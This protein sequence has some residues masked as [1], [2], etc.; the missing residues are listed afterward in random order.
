MK[1]LSF[2]YFMLL[3]VFSKQNNLPNKIKILGSFELIR[4]GARTP[5]I[6]KEQS[7]LYFGT[8]RSQLTINGFRQHILLGRWLRRRYVLED[9][10]PL[11]KTDFNLQN[12]DEIKIKSSNFQRCVFSA[13]AH[14]LGLFPKAIIKLNYEGHQEIK[15]NDIPPIKNYIEDIRDGR[16]VTIN[17][18]NNQKENLFKIS[19][20]KYKN[21]T[22]TLKQEIKK[23]HR[24]PINLLTDNEIK[25]AIDDIMTN[26]KEVIIK[27]KKHT[28]DNE[29]AANNLKIHKNNLRKNNLN[30]SEIPKYS[31]H[32]LNEFIS[33]LRPYL[34]HHKMKNNLKNSTLLTIKK[35]CLNKV[36]EV[37][38]KDSPQKL[39]FSSRIFK[40][41]K[42]FFN[43]IIEK[44]TKLKLMILS[45]FDRNI[46]DVISNLLDLNYLKKIIFDSLNDKTLYNFLVPKFASNMIFEL[47]QVEGDKEYYVRLLYNGKEIKKNFSQPIQLNKDELL[48]YED[49]IKLISSKIENYSNVIC[50]DQLIDF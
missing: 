4:H 32:V 17:V 26:H 34:Y 45:G 20:C 18:Q 43:K 12:L 31:L 23:Y 9:S 14:I 46:M 41:I 30:G 10:L 48:N 37:R 27:K 19:E 16:E 5:L 29:D 40:K 33:V 21:S 1:L 8:Q 42:S 44:K 15:T 49:F 47:L 50:D 6:N 35:H 28:V 3:I 24:I 39:L 25:E 11:L 22:M 2:L 7:H 38:I 13:S 36:Y